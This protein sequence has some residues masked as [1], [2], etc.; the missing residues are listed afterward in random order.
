MQIKI[1]REHVQKYHA[2]HS[3]KKNNK[4]KTPFDRDFLVYECFV[5][6][7]QTTSTN[8]KLSIPVFH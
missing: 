2:T 7:T 8:K 5:A 6:N 3:W 4:K 1:V